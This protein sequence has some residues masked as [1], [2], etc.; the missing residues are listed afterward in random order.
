M[1]D[2]LPAREGKIGAAIAK[3]SVLAVA[4]ILL[5]SWGCSGAQLKGPVPPVT[6]G[7]DEAKAGG[8]FVVAVPR[9]IPGVDPNNTGEVFLFRSSQPGRL[10]P[11]PSI[12]ESLTTSPAFAAFDSRGDLFVGNR[13]ENRERGPGSISRFTLHPDGSF[14]PRGII[15]GG[16]LSSVHGLAFAPNGDLYAANLRDGTIS[17]FGFD[18]DRE[19]VPLGL[20]TVGGQIEG[21]ACDR[22]GDLFVTTYNPPVVRRFRP[23]PATGRLELVRSFTIPGANG[24]HGL[25]F[26]PRGE[27]L[28][29]SAHDD[30]VY[31]LGF[32][33][34]GG[35]F[36]AGT[37]PV[38]GGPVGVAFA[39]TGELFVS[40]HLRG[41]IHRFLLDPEG[42]ADS[43]GVTPME[44]LGGIAIFPA[45]PI[46]A[47]I[48]PIA[49]KPPAPGIEWNLARDFRPFPR[50]ANPNPGANGQAAWYFLSSGSLAHD[51]AGYVLME[52]HQVWGPGYEEWYSPVYFSPPDQGWA[53]MVGF[54]GTGKTL[55]AEG[56]TPP[57]Y[58]IPPGVVF[59]HP[60]GGSMAI[61]GW[62]CPF[63]GEFD[64]TASFSELDPYPDKGWDGVRWSVDRGAATLA[65]GEIA[66]GGPSMGVS[67]RGVRVRPGEF[68]FF[69]V[70]PL[71]RLE[72]DLTQ[73]DVT[74]RESGQAGAAAAPGRAQ[75][76]EGRR[77]RE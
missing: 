20:F 64:V 51:P 13:H 72:G 73:V 61:V 21:L 37:I 55:A 67:I 54:N 74:I 65:S 16:G 26:S 31:R 33:P 5:L 38:P 14:T 63:D 50:Q 52:G 22:E 48:S 42:T 28:V 36:V 56:V 44:N 30:R 29:T 24:L 77:G 39:P 69:T 41:G 62:R 15:T 60:A 35:M 53:P 10:D 47:G 7:R 75:A 43:L 66:Q 59:L 9:T 34:E 57:G 8:G 70:D 25:A 76:P 2:L 6:P 4:G 27:L 68:L 32:G 58:S 19:P 1:R 12:P 3:S 71:R 49:P 18:R 11:L 23:E 17:R 40:T 46:R 45:L